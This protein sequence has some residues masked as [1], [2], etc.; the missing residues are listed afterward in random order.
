MMRIRRRRNRRKKSRKNLPKKLLDADKKPKSSKKK[1]SKK[2]KKPSS[3]KE[4]APEEED[5]FINSIDNVVQHT[6][7]EIV[8]TPDEDTTEE[9]EDVA[10]PQ[11]DF[12]SLRAALEEKS[13]DIPPPK[14]E[15]VDDL[16]V[17]DDE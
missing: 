16:F 6:S 9:G 5:D 12:K 10:S 1:K 8:F 17:K 3:D 7:E 11:K 13:A 4:I 2:D 14:P 15:N